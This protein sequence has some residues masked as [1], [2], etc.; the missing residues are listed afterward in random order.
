MGGMFDVLSP[1]ACPLAGFNHAAMTNMA[2]AALGGWQAV[3]PEL[4]SAF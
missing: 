4:Q 3:N 1:G 2:L